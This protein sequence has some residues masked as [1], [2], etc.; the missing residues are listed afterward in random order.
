MT[1]W[2]DIFQVVQTVI[3]VVTVIVVFIVRNSFKIGSVTTA[4]ARDIAEAKADIIGVNQRMDRAGREMSNLAT[5]VQGLPV[6]W[7]SDCVTRELFDRADQENKKD[8]E[9]MQRQIDLLWAAVYRSRLDPRMP[10]PPDGRSD[11]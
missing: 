9:R 11:T 3:M 2:F 1:H 4:E 6:M 7:R 8:R 10:P 5:K